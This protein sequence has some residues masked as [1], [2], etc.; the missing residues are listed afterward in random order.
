MPFESSCT[1]VPPVIA[2]PTNVSRDTVMFGGYYKPGKD[3]VESG[4]M[5]S[6]CCA[7]LSED[8]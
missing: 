8:A 1:D 3:E 4:S 2:V 5:C 6:A 7:E